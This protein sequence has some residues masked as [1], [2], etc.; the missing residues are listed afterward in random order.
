M[1]HVSA[2]ELGLV[3]LSGLTVFLLV[4]SLAN[5]QVQARTRPWRRLAQRWLRPQTLQR[6]DSY[7]LQAGLNRW[8]AADLWAARVSWTGLA[9]IG[10]LWFSQ[11][12]WLGLLCALMGWVMFGQ[13]FGQRIKRNQAQL[14]AELP[15]FL[16]L[17]S[18]C[19]SAGMNL[20][21]GVQ[22]VLGYQDQ[23][24]LT[25]LWRSWLLQV[26]SGM[27]RAEAFKSMLVRMQAQALR[28]ICVALIQAEEVG[29]GMATSLM[30]HS[31][32]LRQQRLMQAEKQALQAPVKMLLPLVVCFFPC[33]FLVLGFSIYVNLGAIFD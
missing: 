11:S 23:T 31:K 6:Y 22:L 19:L 3:T 15:L 2:I 13:W 21:T 5:W 18:M 26:R 17:L 27:T 4:Y 30:V 1:G 33:T 8:Q 7:C 25:Q 20:Q 16:D 24:P 12:G 14:T 29:S 32:Q 28:R 9:G 10:A